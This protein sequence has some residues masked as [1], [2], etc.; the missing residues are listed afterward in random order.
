M[1]TTQEDG[2]DK[3]EVDGTEEDDFSAA[4]SSRAF[5]FPV[6]MGKDRRTTYQAAKNTNENRRLSLKKLERQNSKKMVME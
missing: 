2:G 6:A 5:N 3:K 4:L 1:Q